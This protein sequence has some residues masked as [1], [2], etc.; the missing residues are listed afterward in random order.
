MPQ[1]GVILSLVL[2]FALREFQAEVS[3]VFMPLFADHILH[4]GPRGYGYLTMAQGLGA[5]VRLFGIAGLG[6]SRYKGRIIIGA[7]F[8]YGIISLPFP[9][10]PVAASVVHTPFLCQWSQHRI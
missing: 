7:G 9:S 8:A 6:N 3:S 2:I 4:A 5:M 10:V 1:R